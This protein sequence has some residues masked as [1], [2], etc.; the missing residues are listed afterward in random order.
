MFVRINH[1]KKEGV[2]IFSFSAFYDEKTNIPWFQDYGYNYGY[3]YISD[4][5]YI[6][7]NNF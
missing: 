3:N 4:Y 5:D 1:F 2:Q 7:D 6:C